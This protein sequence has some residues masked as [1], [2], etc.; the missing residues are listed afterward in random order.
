MI[1]IV[2]DMTRKKED[3]NGLSTSPIYKVWAS[4]LDRCYNSNT[5]NYE[6]YGGRGIT[7][8]KE[9]INS[10][11]TFYKDMG[12]RPSNYSIERIDNNKGYSK[13]NCKW[14]S[15][16]EQSNNKRSTIKIKYNDKVQ[17]LAEWCEELSINYDRTYA[18]LFTY[19]YS[20]KKA[21]D[22]K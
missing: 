12:E 13:D 20:I 5:R 2:I 4:M 18:R 16:K 8:S 14:A 9:W 10:F 3:V 22:E 15:I 19:N 1:N 6:S 7:V 21:F 17:S 11:N